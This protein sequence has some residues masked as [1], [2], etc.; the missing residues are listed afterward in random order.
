MAQRIRPKSD[1]LVAVERMLEPKDKREA[2]R[3]L[4]FV[5]YLAKFIPNLAKH[6]QAIRDVCKKYVNFSWNVPQQSAFAKIKQLI[7]QSPTLAIYDDSKPLT[8]SVDASSNSLGACL[9]Q[10]GKPIEF[11]SK[12]LSPCQRNY[13]QI[14]KELLAVYFGCSRFHLFTYA[15]SNV[16]I[17]TDHKPLIGLIKKDLNTLSPRLAGLRLKLMPYSNCELK[18]RPG[19]ELIIADTLSRTCPAGSNVEDDLKNVSTVLVSRVNFLDNGVVKSYVDATNMDEELSVVKKL[20]ASGWPTARKCVPQRALPYWSIREMLTVDDSGLVYYGKRLVVPVSKRQSVLEKLHN[21]HQGV[22]KTM[23]KAQESVYWPGLRRSVEDRCLSCSACQSVG[24]CNSKEPMIGFPIPQFPF[25]MVGADLFHLDS[26][27][28]LILVDYLS[29][30]P[31]VYPLKHTNTRNVLDVLKQVFAEHGI[32][33]SFMSDNGPQ[34]RSVEF[35]DFCRKHNINH[36]TSSPLHQQGN[37]QTERMV[38]VVKTTMKK[39]INEKKEW[40]SALLT[41]RNTPIDSTCKLTPAQILQGR[42]MRSCLEVPS[43]DYTIHEYSIEKLRSQL[44]QRK[45][46]QKFYYDSHA[47]AEKSVLKIGQSVRFR[48]VNDKWVFGKISQVLGLRSYL[49]TTSLGQQFRRNRRDVKVSFEQTPIPILF[50]NGGVRPVL[51]CRAGPGGSGCWS[52]C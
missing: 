29:K 14:E 13:A 35:A 23:L 16:T 27:E 42:H 33:Q 19:K 8:V 50:S 3:F 12:S 9:M 52:S 1:K 31:F 20:V 51:P 41:L 21:A 4:G 10:D 37:G 2:E 15:R 34:F 22:S 11:A 40:W 5:T 26:T 25:Q 47:N 49:I 44:D 38:G 48:T 36:V 43:I 30:F 18:W 7:L 32:P 45:T 6:T 28:Y 46:V 24:S 39:C 17:E